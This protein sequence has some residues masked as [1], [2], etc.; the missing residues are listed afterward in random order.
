[1]ASPLSLI[2]VMVIK[3]LKLDLRRKIEAG[4]IAV[5][6]IAAAMLTSFSIHS[7]VKAVEPT[8][9]LVMVFLSVFASLASF[10]RESEQGTLEGLRAAPISPELLFIA[11]LVYSFV[12]IVAQELIYIVSLVFFTQIAAL[13]SPS[14]IALLLFSALYLSA[15]SSFASSLLVYS[16][17][18]GVL[19]PVT[20][21]VLVLPFIQYSSPIVSSTLLGSP[22]SINAIASLAALSIGFTAIVVFLSRFIIEAL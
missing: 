5:F 20:I 14:L 17:A 3:D 2:L 8:L 18:R 6:S 13:L 22:A 15:S 9:M 12:L 1:M 4:S 10:I 16:E 19:L 21:L 11:K 7:D